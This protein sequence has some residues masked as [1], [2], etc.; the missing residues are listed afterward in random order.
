MSTVCPSSLLGGLVDLDV[1]DNQVAG[2][3]TLGVGVGLSVLQETEEELGGLGGPAG[4]GDTK[5]LA[6]SQNRVSI[7]FILVT[8][9]AVFLLQNLPDPQ[10]LLLTISP[11][12][13]RIQSQCLGGR[14][15]N[16]TLSSSA[17]AAGV[18]AHGDSLLLL[19]DVLEELDG[20]L[21]LPAVDGLGSLPG[22]LEG[23][24]EVGTAGAGRL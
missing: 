12:S 2:V 11:H 4:L 7:S 16:R 15:K 18:A 17:S 1:L 6:Y 13:I 14:N 23:N 10:C 9:N 20:A 5:L 21:Q 3:E 8:F 24:A 19:L 22:I